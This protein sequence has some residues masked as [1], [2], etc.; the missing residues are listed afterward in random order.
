MSGNAGKTE[1]RALSGVREE[2]YNLELNSLK[3]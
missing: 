1:G 2:Q 3:K